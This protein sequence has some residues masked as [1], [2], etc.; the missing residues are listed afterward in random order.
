MNYLNLPLLNDEEL[1]ILK[2]DLFDINELWE[3]GRKTAGTHAAKVKK[4]L[5]LKRDSEISRKFTNLITKKCFQY[6]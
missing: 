6:L 3:D 2:R 5:Q 1:K 4:N